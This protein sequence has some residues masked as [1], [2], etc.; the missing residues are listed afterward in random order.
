VV[1]VYGK[2]AREMTNQN[3]LENLLRSTQK[4]CERLREENTRLR[5]MLGIQKSTPGE[6]SQTVIPV[7]I[8]S[9]SRSAGPPAPE[10]KIT[11][12]RTLFRGREDIYAVRWEGKNGRSGYSPAGVMNWRAIHAA[13]PEDLQ[14]LGKIL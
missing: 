7:E 14:K 8:I 5:A 2:T 6:L 1:F 10:R 12:F 3:N 4:K 11:L 9:E 13:K